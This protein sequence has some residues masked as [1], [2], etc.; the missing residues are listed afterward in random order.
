MKIIHIVS[1]E[2]FINSAFWQFNEVFPKQNTFFLLV[3]DLNQNLKYVNNKNNYLL[4]EKRLGQLEALAKDEALKGIVCFHG[5]DYHKSFLL[6]KLSSSSKIIWFVWGAEVYNNP[7]IVSQGDLY[8]F[9]TRT[10]FLGFS[11][12]KILKNKFRQFFY[13]IKIG[14]DGPNKLIL[15][16]I[17]RADYCAVLYREEYEFIER[18]VTSNLKYLKFSYYP[19]QL[20]ISDTT[21]RISANNILVGNSSSDTNNHL[22]VF[23]LLKDLPIK[24]KKIV[25]PLSYGEPE[26]RDKIISKGKRILKNNFSPLVDFMPLHQYNEFLKQC[27]IVIMNHYRQQAVGNVITMLWMGAKVYLDERNTLFSY[28]NRIGVTVFSIQK[29]LRSENTE[30]FTLLSLEEQ[31]KNRELLKMEVGE[32]YLL[33]NLNTQFTDLINEP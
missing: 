27:G 2:K 18:K 29:E 6:N 21:A 13:R 3:D 31:D 17:K 33:K 4:I 26:Y 12:I 30:V 10:T 8:G 20:M 14:T 19:I 28:F 15:N 23:K 24:N 16:A 1:D 25:V 7:K 32:E 5:L 11:F 9:Y 22:E